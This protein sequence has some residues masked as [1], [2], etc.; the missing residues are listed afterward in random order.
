MFNFTPTPL[1]SSEHAIW[2]HNQNDLEVLNDMGYGAGNPYTHIGYVV[3]SNFEFLKSGLKM[4]A[5]INTNGRWLLVTDDS[6]ETHQASDLLIHAWSTY[7]MVNILLVHQTTAY[8]YDPFAPEIVQLDLTLDSVDFIRFEARTK[9]VRGYPLKTE[10]ISRR[11]GYAQEEIFH[12]FDNLMDYVMRYIN[13]TP[14]E[15]S[16]LLVVSQISAQ[17]TQGQFVGAHKRINESTI[18]LSMVSQAVTDLGKSNVAYLYSTRRINFFYV[19]KN[20][21]LQPKIIDLRVWDEHSETVELFC[22]SLIIIIWF[23]LEQCGLSKSRHGH[24]LTRVG[25]TL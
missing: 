18:E 3:R 23:I 20:R 2:S 22:L 17:S 9:N 25:L 5:R 11:I 10:A 21:P 14:E 12:V 19:V 13:A 6:I 15:V 1:T 7:N 24:G 4:F 8:F 16:N